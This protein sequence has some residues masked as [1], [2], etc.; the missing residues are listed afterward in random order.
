MGSVVFLHGVG[1]GTPGWDQAMHSSL[2]VAG[3]A[4]DYE[5]WEI[6][7]DD[8]VDRPGVIRR[9]STQVAAGIAESD[10]AATAEVSYRHRMRELRREVW[11]SPDRVESPKIIPPTILPGEVM[12]RLPMLGM[13][14]AGHYRHNEAVQSAVI[15]RVS[16]AIAGLE[17]PT[18]VIA[19][20]LG[21]VVALDTVHLRDVHTALLVSI[22]SPLGVKDFWGAS[23]QLPGRFPFDRVGAWLNVVNVKD[24]VALGRGVGPRFPQALDVYISGGEGLMGPRNFHDAATYTA[25][26]VIGRAVAAALS[27]EFDQ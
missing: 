4:G 6:D 19:H 5:L 20:S 21:S 24:P 23:W 7:F 13:R 17:P 11:G 15:D 26:D 22:G 8:L 25:S 12:V 9:G 16:E 14:Q 3:F 18:V 2:E 27:G 10:Q 1:G